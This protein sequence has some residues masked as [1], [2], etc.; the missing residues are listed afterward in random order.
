[1][2]SLLHGLGFSSDER[3][4]RI[5]LRTSWAAFLMSCMILRTR[6]PAALLP[7][8]A[9]ATSSAAEST[10]CLRC[11]YSCISVSPVLDYEEQYR[12]L[13]RC[14][15]RC[16]AGAAVYQERAVISNAQNPGFEGNIKV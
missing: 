10:S 7:P 1:M 16:A 9:L 11:S 14:R 3:T 8:S 5:F 4:S 12:A 15:R 13:N 6:V 2:L